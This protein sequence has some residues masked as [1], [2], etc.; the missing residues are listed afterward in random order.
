M[1]KE[2]KKQYKKEKKD[3]AWAHIFIF[4]TSLEE[5][6]CMSQA[7]EMPLSLVCMMR[8]N[9]NYLEWL[10]IHIMIVVL[11]LIGELVLEYLSK[12]NFYA[13]LLHLGPK[14]DYF[15]NA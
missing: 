4:P 11:A 12:W 9:L 14:P 3:W 8:S 13:M 1:K 10:V 7:Y 15:L 6:Y 5:N 2:G